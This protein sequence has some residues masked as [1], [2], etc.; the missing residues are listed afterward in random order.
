MRYHDCLFER[1]Y[2]PASSED[3]WWDCERVVAAL[4]LRFCG[5]ALVHATDRQRH[6]T[7]SRCNL[8]CD[9]CLLRACLALVNDG[10]ISQGS[11]LYLLL[12]FRLARLNQKRSRARDVGSFIDD[13]QVKEV[14]SAFHT[15]LSYT[16]SLQSRSTHA[17]CVV[18]D[19]IQCRTPNGIY[20]DTVSIEYNL[21][22]ASHD[23]HVSSE[24]MSAESLTSA[25]PSFSLHR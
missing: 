3:R 20:G 7:D 18:N 12:I 16:V 17:A 10:R 19:L 22:T 1:H 6:L 15:L 23:L 8:H 21:Q 5:R 4:Q 2:V 13:A 24:W 14:Q 11:F 25:C 9:R